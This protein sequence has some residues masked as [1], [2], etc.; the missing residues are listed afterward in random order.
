[1][2]LTPQDR[3][4]RCGP[5]DL[6]GH[7]SASASVGGAGSMTVAIAAA[8]SARHHGLEPG[9]HRFRSPP[10]AK[11]SPRYSRFLLSSSGGL[12]GGAP[13]ATLLIAAGGN[14]DRLAHA[15]VFAALCEVSPVEM[16]PAKLSGTRSSAAATT[17]PTQPCSA[18]SSPHP[19][20]PRDPRPPAATHR[21][22]PHATR[23]HPLPNG[24]CRATSTRSSEQVCPSSLLP[25]IPHLSLTT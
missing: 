3:P 17:K 2:F 13:S 23:D 12:W 7:P 15:A 6:L 18:S 9:P 22:R 19:L 4:H 21:R 16:P 11:E 20:P 25:Q 10:P 24:T 14:P 5:G 1:M 8:S